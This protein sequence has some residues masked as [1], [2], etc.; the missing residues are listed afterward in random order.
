MRF[1]ALDLSKKSAGWASWEEGQERPISGAWN[2]GSEFTPAGGVFL[3]LF[4]ELTALSAVCGESE[5]RSAFDDII[6][7]E[8]LN[9]GPANGFTNKDTLFLLMGLAATVDLWAEARRARKVRCTNQSSWRRHFLGSIPRGPRKD[10]LGNRIKPKPINWKALA[11]E[12]CRELGFAPRSHD[13]AEALGILDY[14]I[15]LAGITPPWRMQ[16][17]LVQQLGSA[18]A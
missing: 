15:S 6:Y 4:Q 1:L 8:P 11:E 13:E 9:L 7:E 14:S 5:R 3:N 12:R 2:L 16:H 17:V 10:E 18:A